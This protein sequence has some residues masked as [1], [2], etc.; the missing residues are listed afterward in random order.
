[1]TIVDDEYHVIRKGPRM[2]HHHN[3]WNGNVKQPA[4]CFKGEFIFDTVHHLINVKTQRMLLIIAKK[5]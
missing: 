4:H 5:E 3:T 1:M 2:R